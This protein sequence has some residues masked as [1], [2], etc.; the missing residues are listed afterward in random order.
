MAVP[1]RQ[2]ALKAAAEP[3]PA[4][5]L[6]WRPDGCWID[7]AVVPNAKRTEVIGLHD[8]ALR[9]R[10]SAPPVDGAAN[11]ALQRWLADAIGVSRSRVSLLKGETSRRK[12]V[13]V[14]AEAGQI[15]LWLAGLPL[16]AAD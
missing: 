15:R 14:R 6:T 12:R 10:L 7:L 5:F 2:Q 9:V 11:D 13:E 8:Q 3:A 4:P 16:P 1:D